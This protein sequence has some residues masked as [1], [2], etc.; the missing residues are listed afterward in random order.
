MEQQVGGHI[1]VIDSGIGGLGVLSHLQKNLPKT[2]FSYVA[3][4]AFFPYGKLDN[5]TLCAR[6][7]DMVRKFDDVDCVV[8][9]CNTASTVVL[10]YMREE[11][12]FPIVG[13]VP[14]IKVAARYTKTKAFGILATEA[15]ANSRYTRSLMDEFASDC[16]IK[17]H[18]SKNLARLAEQKLNGSRVLIADVENEI[19]PL[20]TSMRF[21]E[22]K[23]IDHVVLGCTHYPF[24]LAE[25]KQAAPYEVTWIDPAEAVAKRVLDVI[26]PVMGGAARGR[27]KYYTTAENSQYKV[28]NIG[29]DKLIF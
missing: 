22:S 4:E 16:T 8:I 7:A 15:T 27:S 17:L 18:G 20:F 10:P 2:R 23:R 1:L 21:R 25:L 12:D 24:L 3:D 11:F 5:E 28:R 19:L 9:A 14:A 26:K 29:F 13:I 6:C